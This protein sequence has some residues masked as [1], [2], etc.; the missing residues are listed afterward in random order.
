MPQLKKLKGKRLKAALHWLAFLKT[1]KALMT[2][3][4]ED[5][6]E[7]TDEESDGDE[8]NSDN[9]DDDDNDDDGDE[10]N[11]DNGDDDDD[12]DDD[13]DTEEESREMS[14]KEYLYFVDEAD[15]FVNKRIKRF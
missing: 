2:V 15:N 13:E 3:G 10:E 7:D 14:N 1:Q 9:G 4:L 11:S 8:K 6:S 12:G 5:N